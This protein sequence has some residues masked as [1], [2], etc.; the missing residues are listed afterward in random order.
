MHTGVPH[1]TFDTDTLCSNMCTPCRNRCI[2]CWLADRDPKDEFG[3]ERI[4]GARFFDVDAVSESATD[5]PHM[6]PSVEA[7]AAAA[8][9]L[10]IRN[11]SQVRSPARCV[12]NAF[13]PTFAF[14]K[15]R[16]QSHKHPGTRHCL[17]CD[18]TDLPRK[19][20][21]LMLSVSSTLGLWDW[22]C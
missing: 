19:Q 14:H 21:R 3:E 9:A 10:G 11:D 1:K 8:D 16:S 2:R 17:V 18:L 6:L 4:P 22:M 5:L 20:N 15:D 7:F 12:S 13:C